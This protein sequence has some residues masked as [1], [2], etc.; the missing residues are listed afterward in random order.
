MT[1]IAAGLAACTDDP[2]TTKA[3]RVRLESLVASKTPGLQYV[4]VDSARTLYEFNGGY[5]DLAQ[6]VPVDSTTTMMA[7]SMSKTLTAAAVLQLAEAGRVDLDAPVSRYVTSQPYGDAVTVRQLLAHT[8][9]LPNPI[10]LKWVHLASAHA[11]FDEG[12]ALA[13]VLAEHAEPQGA[14]GKRYAY[15][16][17]GYWLLGRVVE[18]VTGEAFTDYV[19]THVLRRI[20]AAESELG[21][22]IPDPAHHARG[23]LERY[24]FPN[25]LK[26]FLIDDEFIGEYEGRWLR[27]ESHYLNS[28]AMGGLVGTSRGFG[29]FL[30]DQLRSRSALFGEE[31]RRLFYEPQRTSDGKVIDMTLGWHVGV[32]DGVRYFYK[33]G[34]GGGFHSMMRLYPDRGVGSVLIV[35]ATT[36]NVRKALDEVDR[37]LFGAS[38]GPMC[39]SSIPDAARNGPVSCRRIVP[40]RDGPPSSVFSAFMTRPARDRPTKPP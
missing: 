30:Q 25:L 19:S 29:K 33:E 28:P 24:S 40:A 20:G 11:G 34:G 16:N 27:I 17:I 7:Y 38:I 12:A 4:L 14:P 23:Y 5:A 1:T 22:G 2:A 8:A 13:S 39:H 21:F 6:R 3:V 32:L 36:M 18:R 31:A 15:A 9:G 35:N 10:P 26:G 37:A